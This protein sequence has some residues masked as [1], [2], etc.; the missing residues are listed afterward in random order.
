[1][2][3]SFTDFSHGFKQSLDSLA[4]ATTLDFDANNLNTDPKTR[5]SFEEY[6]RVSRVALDFTKFEDRWAWTMSEALPKWQAVEATNAAHILRTIVLCGDSSLL[7]TPVNWLK[8]RLGRALSGEIDL[9][10]NLAAMLSLGQ[11]LVEMGKSVITDLL[12]R[13]VFLPPRNYKK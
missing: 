13:W 8:K 5:A 9:F 12:V 2:Q 1:M 4:W 7:I 3:R 6:E 10:I 11:R